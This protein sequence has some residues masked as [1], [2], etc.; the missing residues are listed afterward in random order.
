[1]CRQRCGGAWWTAV[2]TDGGLLVVRAEVAGRVVD[3]RVTGGVVADIGPR[4]RPSPRDDVLD[5]CGGA[6][7]PGLH[8]HHLHLL[9]LAAAAS[10]VDCGPPQVRTAGQLGDALLT[11]VPELSAVN[12]APSER[13]RQATFVPLDSLMRPAPTPH[14]R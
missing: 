11:A 1:M 2:P 7:L 5:A 13:A 9:A 14:G 3:V 10:S 8:D 4:L 6:L 12:F